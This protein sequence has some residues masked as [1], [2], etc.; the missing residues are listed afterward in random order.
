MLLCVPI[1]TQAEWESVKGSRSRTSRFFEERLLNR[2]GGREGEPFCR[3]SFSA[4]IPE[5]YLRVL[6]RAPEA[7]F[8][9]LCNPPYS[10]KSQLLSQLKLISDVES[11][12]RRMKGVHFESNVGLNLLSLASELLSW[13]TSR[14]TGAICC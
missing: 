13:W 4:R 5:N 9:T 2:N 12:V 8:H 1:S 3:K 6:D 11:V 10:I 14:N 7:L